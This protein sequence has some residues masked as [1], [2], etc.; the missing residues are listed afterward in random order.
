H[1]STTILPWIPEEVLEET[2]ETFHWSFFQEYLHHVPW[3]WQ[4][5][6]LNKGLSIEVVLKNMD[7]SWHWY[8]L[9]S[10]T[11]AIPIETVERY[12]WL[13]WNYVKISGRESED[14]ALIGFMRRHPEK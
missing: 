4:G 9:S 3:D 5:L 14:D 2:M 8:L 10:N 6:S 1:T 7:A 12:H 13:N 11:D